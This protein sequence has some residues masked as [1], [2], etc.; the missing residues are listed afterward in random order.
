MNFLKKHGLLLI[1]LQAIVAMAGSLYFGFF[2]DP[3]TNFI[4]RDMWNWENG[5]PP[6]DLCWYARILMYP[7]VWF[8]II[9]LVRKE[10]KCIVN[11]FIP[12]SL[13]GMLLTWYH[14]FLQKVNVGTS[15]F[16]TA[17]N[18]CDALSVN[19]FGFITIPFLALL[20]FTV[21]LVLSLL[22]RKAL[23]QDG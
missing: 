10:V 12:V 15:F 11:Y 6:C 16:C 1:V 3:Y 9:A 20:A 18:P 21:I 19:Y 8:S 4:L 13:A 23:K 5:F 17:A 7:I 2:G 14:Y 22:T